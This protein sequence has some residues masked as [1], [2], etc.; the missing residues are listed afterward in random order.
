MFLFVRD[1][2]SPYPAFRPSRDKLGL[3]VRHALFPVPALGAHLSAAAGF[4][5]LFSTASGVFSL[6]AGLRNVF[7]RFDLS[8]AFQLASAG[9]CATGSRTRSRHVCNRFSPRLDHLALVGHRFWRCVGHCHG[10]RLFT[11]RL[12]FSYSRAVPFLTSPGFGRFSSDL[13]GPLA[14]PV[15]TLIL[16]LSSRFYLGR[17]QRFCVNSARVIRPC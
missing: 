9:G 16:S 17:S 8:E 5:T 12:L 2:K 3:G 14:F 6:V 10:S 15:R 11:L 1:K 4:P 7:R 13:P